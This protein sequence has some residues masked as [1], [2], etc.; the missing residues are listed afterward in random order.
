[1]SEK[2][3]WNLIRNNLNLKMYRV[4]NRVAVGMPD[5]HYVS[6]NSSGW[7]ELKYIPEMAKKG[8]V[9]TG[10]RKSQATWHD[11]YCKNGG[12]S[13]LLFRIERRGIF[14]INGSMCKRI[15]KGKTICDLMKL[16]SWSKM[17]NMSDNDWYELGS[18]IDGRKVEEDYE[19]IGIGK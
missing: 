6:E 1:M 18:F 17:G 14:L 9:K 19:S 3:F 4:E 2:N 8:K 7:I 5:V 13:W 10:I 16:C 12:T 11:S 15:S